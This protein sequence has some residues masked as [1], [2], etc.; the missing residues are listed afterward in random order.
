MCK[1]IFSCVPFVFLFFS[2][3]QCLTC[4]RNQFHCSEWESIFLAFNYFQRDSIKKKSQLSLFLC[5]PH[6]VG[7]V[8]YVEKKNWNYWDWLYAVIYTL[9]FCNLQLLSVLSILSVELGR[10]SPYQ[11]AA[12]LLCSFILSFYVAC[13]RRSYTTWFILQCPYLIF[14]FMSSHFLFTT[15][16]ITVIIWEG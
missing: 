15:K 6:D 8:S 11:Q 13:M 16:L 3:Q 5:L 10:L 7:K 2:S 9:A 4:V 1:V 14:H 12:R